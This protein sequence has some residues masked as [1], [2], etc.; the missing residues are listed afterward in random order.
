MV[1]RV[2]DSEKSDFGCIL[3]AEL[4]VSVDGLNGGV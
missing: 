4:T 3:K 1:R 2:R